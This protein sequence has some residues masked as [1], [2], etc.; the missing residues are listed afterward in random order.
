MY[1]IQS[2]VENFI[3][4]RAAASSS[5]TLHRASLSGGGLSQAPFP[6]PEYNTDTFTVIIGF[7]IGFFI[8][9]AYIWPFT[10]LVKSLV[11]EKELKIKEV[12]THAIVLYAC[13]CVHVYVYVCVLCYSQVAKMMGLSDTVLW[14]SWF[15]TY[16]V[17]FF[18][19]SL[20][21]MIITCTAIFPNADAGRIFGTHTMYC[22]HS[23]SWC[24]Y[25]CDNG[26]CNFHSH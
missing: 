12:S 1:V 4:Q 21:L 9:I 11:E 8:I 15:I 23:S 16:V 6:T 14:L 3:L 5:I 20:L 17:M 7:T 22:A 10:R 18:V 13:M 25:V 26:G 19:A 24:C 2:F